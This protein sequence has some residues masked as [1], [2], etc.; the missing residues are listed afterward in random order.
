MAVAGQELAPH[1]AAVRG[2]GF[3]SP[4]VRERR[5]FPP[6]PRPLPKPEGQPQ[7]PHRRQSP[8][9]GRAGIPS[10]ATSL[11]PNYPA[12][13]LH[14]EKSVLPPPRFLQCP[15]P[16]GLPGLPPPPL[17]RRPAVSRSSPSSHAEPG[18]G[19]GCHGSRDPLAHRGGE[20]DPDGE[21]RRIAAYPSPPLP[22]PAAGRR[23]HER[24]G[25]PPQRPAPKPLRRPR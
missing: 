19:G 13:P 4:A 2:G 1:S 3:G 12:T 23:A 5:L 15:S 24:R 17:P 25:P 21:G 8:L 9:S 10:P 11:P 6:R 20:S 14:H 7:A 16:S 18:G 22:A